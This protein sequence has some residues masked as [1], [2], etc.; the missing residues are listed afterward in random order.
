MRLV[1][2]FLTLLSLQV[3]SNIYK[4]LLQF[5]FPIPV[6]LSSTS[7]FSL[8]AYFPGNS[9]T[10]VRYCILLC[11]LQKFCDSSTLQ[12]MTAPEEGTCQFLGPLLE[13]TSKEMPIYT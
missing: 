4:Y 13:L 6:L 3:S 11:K 2:G 1:E 5:L 7:L 12:M 9:F 10:A 8:F